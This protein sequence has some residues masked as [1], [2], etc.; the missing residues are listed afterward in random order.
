MVEDPPSLL[1]TTK[2]LLADCKLS[3]ER[4][5][6]DAGVGYYWLRKFRQGKIANPGI[7]NLQKLHDHLV[8]LPDHVG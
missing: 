5:A 7:Q 2:E 8:A 3:A 6:Q 1:K 4:L